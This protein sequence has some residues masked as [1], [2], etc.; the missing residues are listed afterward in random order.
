[1]E[2]PT[3][4]R[5]N[6]SGLPE[7]PWMHRVLSGLQ[8][9]REALDPVLPTRVVDWANAVKNKNLDKPEMAASTRRRLANTFRPHVRRLEDLLDRDLSHWL[10]A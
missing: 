10:G 8:P 6:A 7:H 5:V 1:V 9:V 2:L 3:E 4:R